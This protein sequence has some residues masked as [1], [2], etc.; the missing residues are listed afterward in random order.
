MRSIARSS[1]AAGRERRY[2]AYE[3]PPGAGA[4][5]ITSAS[6]AWAISSA[7][8]RAA[9]AIAAARPA[10]SSG[11]NSGTPESTRKHLKPNTPAACIPSSSP[12]LPG[13]APPQNPTSMCACATAH[14]RLRCRPATVVVAGMLLSGM[15][16]TVV[17][18]PA[19]AARVPVSKPSHSVRPG[20]LMCTCVSTSPGSSTS[21]SASAHGLAAR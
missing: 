17:T 1:A 15:S 13:T 10:G 19:A 5:A 12:T 18:P 3:G 7:P 6:S 14:S 16:I 20:S 11:G 4:A 2:V 8:S 9:S 21:P